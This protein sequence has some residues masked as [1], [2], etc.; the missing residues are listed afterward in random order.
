MKKTSAV[1]IAA[2]AALSLTACGNNDNA[3]GTTRSAATSSKPFEDVTIESSTTQNSK[4][5]TTSTTAS[6]TTTTT[7]KANK[8]TTAT[9][10]KKAT[11]VTIKSKKATAKSTTTSTVS[12]TSTMAQKTTRTAT[13]TELELL[14]SMA[15][16]KVM[17]EY[18]KYQASQSAYI[19][20]LKGEIADLQDQAGA[21]YVDYQLQLRSLKERYS[22]MGLLNS[23]AY[24]SAQQSL[25]Y[26]YKGNVAPISKR[27]E[28]LKKELQQA[29]KDY[30]ESASQCEALI[31][32]EFLA[33]VE[34]F[35]QKTLS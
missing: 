24:V 34:E 4:H 14:Y 22:A 5:I 31:E 18:Y 9:T 16:N 23:G 21:F 29:E 30:D 12:T 2:L 17:A 13:E 1:I 27:V 25:E 6:R 15:Y 32:E 20:E 3:N 10:T 26:Q 11:T 33:A 35:Q 7:E 19:N 28:E 8:P